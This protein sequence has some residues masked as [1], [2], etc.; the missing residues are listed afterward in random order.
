MRASTR[1]ADSVFHAF[2]RH[3]LAVD[4]ACGTGDAFVEECTAEVICA[5]AQVD[6]GT[7]VM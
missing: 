1:F 7:A 6:G 5:G 3:F 2:E 4:R